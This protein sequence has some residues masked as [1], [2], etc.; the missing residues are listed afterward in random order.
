MERSTLSEQGVLVVGSGGMTHNLGALI[1]NE[2]A[3]VVPWAKAF[4]HWVTKKLESRDDNS[5]LN[6][7]K[8]AP[9]AALAH[10]TT[11]HFAPLF[12]AMGAA[13]VESQP[14]FPVDMFRYGSLSL[15]SVAF[16]SPGAHS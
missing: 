2:K 9:N 1:P 7:W 5:L 6:F 16:W 3:P 10:P 14:S 11:E 8:D 4:D 15:R 12:V 13:G